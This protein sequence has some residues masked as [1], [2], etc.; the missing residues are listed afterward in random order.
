M[1][2]T[3]SNSSCV[4]MLLDYIPFFLNNQSDND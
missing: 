4:Y 2:F 3:F 1:E